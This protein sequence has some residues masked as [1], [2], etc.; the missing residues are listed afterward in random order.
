MEYL[1]ENL[2]ENGQAFVAVCRTLCCFMPMEEDVLVPMD[3]PLSVAVEVQPEETEDWL[4]MPCTCCLETDLQN[5]WCEDCWENWCDSQLVEN[6]DTE[7]V[8]LVVENQRQYYFTE[9]VWAIIMSYLDVSGTQLF[10]DMMMEGIEFNA[11]LGLQ[12]QYFKYF[13]SVCKELAN[14]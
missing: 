5:T 9:E 3:V 12:Y 2:M 11:A 4:A 14:S 6:Q 1:M 7:I 8:S 13:S 10:K